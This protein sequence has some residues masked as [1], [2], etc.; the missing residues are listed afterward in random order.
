M[1]NRPSSSH[2]QLPRVP[3]LRQAG[4]LSVA[5]VSV[6]LL[7]S[8]L[9]AVPEAEATSADL[10]QPA[11]PFADVPTDHWAYEAVLNLYTTYGCLAGYPD[12]TFRG[13]Q[14]VSRYEFAASLSE[15]LDRLSALTAPAATQQEVD[16]LIEMMEEGLRELEG[17]EERTGSEN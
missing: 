12:G 8:R 2:T 11:L 17:L 9:L 1:F 3:W 10:A 4:L 16:A 15:C 6:L 7:P 14:A 5:V 13:D